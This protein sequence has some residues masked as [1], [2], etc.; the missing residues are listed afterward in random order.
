MV[1]DGV[2]PA[3]CRSDSIRPVEEVGT[4]ELVYNI[5]QLSPSHQALL[6]QF[7]S[8]GAGHALVRM[9]GSRFC[10]SAFALSLAIRHLHL[11]LLQ[12]SKVFDATREEIPAAR[13][14][15]TPV[16]PTHVS[17]VVR[18][19]V[20]NSFHI[21]SQLAQEPTCW[22]MSISFDG[23]SKVGLNVMNLRVRIPTED[24]VDSFMLLLAPDVSG[25]DE[26]TAFI[27]DAL[28]AMRANARDKLYGGTADGCTVNMGH[29]T[30][31]TVQLRIVC[32]GPMIFLH[33]PLHQLHLILGEIVDGLGFDEFGLS[34]QDAVSRIRNLGLRPMCPEL[35]ARW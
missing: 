18:G 26:L 21:I 31:V 16:S 1:C 12:T 8:F 22:C 23:C 15:L 32:N 35:S 20:L 14:V 2:V 10:V 9:F 28:D 24:G 6:E 7:I 19:V 27:L 11:P 13:G 30:G 34:I 17:R 33:C 29:H 3:L 5:T 4:G 25:S